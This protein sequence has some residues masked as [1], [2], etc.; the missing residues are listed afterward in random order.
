[1]NKTRI[2]QKAKEVVGLAA[3]RKERHEQCP[4]FVWFRCR[5][6]LRDITQLNHMCSK[7]GSSYKKEK[8]DYEQMAVMSLTYLLDMF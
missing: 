7:V 5:C 1:M 3:L 8:D 4:S 6:L 2:R